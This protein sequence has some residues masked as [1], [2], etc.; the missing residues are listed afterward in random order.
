M[1]IAILGFGREGKAVLDFLKKSPKYDFAQ[2]IVL[3]KDP[4]L[5]ISSEDK[6]RTGPSVRL[7]INKNYLKGLEKFDLLFRYPGVPYNLPEI[8][9]AIKRGTILSS[10]TKLFFENCSSRIIGITGTKGKGTT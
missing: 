2:I 8:Q 1:K 6:K 10:A 9:Q 7:K 3:D 5:K 4:K